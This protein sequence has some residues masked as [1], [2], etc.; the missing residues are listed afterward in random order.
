MCLFTGFGVNREPYQV[1][2]TKSSIH[3]YGWH[4]TSGSILIYSFISQVTLTTARVFW[5]D[6]TCVSASQNML[7]KMILRIAMKCMEVDITTCLSQFIV[8]G[9][10]VFYFSF[11]LI[12]LIFF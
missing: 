5:E 10:K 9:S 6:A 8:L 2:E 12:N 3:F 7:H 1:V 4:R 11:S